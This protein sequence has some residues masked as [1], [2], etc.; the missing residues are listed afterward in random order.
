MYT[1]CWNASHTC[2]IHRETR[3]TL[4]N[5]SVKS[6]TTDWNFSRLLRIT[7]V[8][9]AKMWLGY[10]DHFLAEVNYT[11][12]AEEQTQVS[13]FTTSRQLNKTS[14]QKI[15]T[16]SHD[17]I[18]HSTCRD[19]TNWLVT[20]Q[21]RTNSWNAYVEYTR[22]LILQETIQTLNLCKATQQTTNG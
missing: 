15:R 3:Q 13:A 11:T 16:Y 6:K 12:N 14:P 2:N 9:K 10:T 20:R 4:K 19:S 8:E 22:L 1:N 21:M 5:E 7:N 17:I 18:S